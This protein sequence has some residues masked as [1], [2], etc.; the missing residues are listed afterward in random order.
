MLVKTLIIG[1]NPIAGFSVNN[2][3]ARSFKF[4]VTA[5]VIK[6][7]A[8]ATG[9]ENPLYFDNEF[10]GHSEFESIVAPQLFC[11]TMA[12]EDLPLNELLKDFSPIELDVDVPT[13]KTVAILYVVQPHSR[14]HQTR[15]EFSCARLL[16]FNRRGCIVLE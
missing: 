4:L 11:E 6:R 15:Q 16:I 8:Q 10:A 14:H 5:R 3:Q 9:D 13:E 7:F 1:D 12:F 2:F